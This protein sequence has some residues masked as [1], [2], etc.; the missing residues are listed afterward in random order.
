MDE[1]LTL[2]ELQLIIRD[3][4]YMAL[5]DMYW[6]TAEI[7]E[8]SE[9]YAGHCYMELIEKNA[10]EKNV[11]ARI[12]AIAWC[13]KYRFLKS[14]FENTTGEALRAG[15][16]ILVKVKIEYHELYGLSLNICDI[17]PAYTVGEL[18]LKRQMIIRRLEEDGVYE[19]NRELILPLSIQRIAVISSKTAA[20]YTDFMNHLQSNSF[21]YVFYTKLFESAMQG[22]DT[23][24]GI[25]SALDAIAGHIDKFDIA[26]IIRG[27]GSQIDLSWF[28]NYNI[29]YHITQFPLP[30]ITGIGHDKD[31]SV[32]DMVAHTALKTPTAAA[33]YIIEYMAEVE[34]RIMEMW[35]EISDLA[36]HIIERNR[37]QLESAAIRLFPLSGMML[38][39]ARERLS[40]KTIELINSGREYTRNAGFVPQNQKQRLMSLSYNLLKN[41]ALAFERAGKSIHTGIVNSME[42]K[43]TIIDSFEKTL[44]VMKPENVLRRGYTITYQNGKVMKSAGGVKA[45]DTLKTRFC[46]GNIV[47]RVIDTEL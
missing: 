3:S 8:I 46:D 39:K 6:V 15:L 16:K 21:D 14:F 43:K 31:M 7:S 10:D 19:M 35:T 33:G 9:N 29:A 36:R 34:N 1:R 24:K 23:E 25:I 28:D 20:G 4:L 11:R 41:K 2:T 37:H 22:E 12:R 13:K 32:T 38:S 17:N 18:A 42:R 44:E 45:D 26:V 27:G 30:V 47:S 40:Q 5:P